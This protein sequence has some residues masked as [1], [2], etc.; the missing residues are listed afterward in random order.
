MEYNGRSRTLFG[1]VYRNFRNVVLN[2]VGIERDLET[3][4]DDYDVGRA[5]RLFTDN[6]EDVLRAMQ[7]YDAEEHEEV[8]MRRDK[9][10]E[11][12]DPYIAEKLPRSLQRYINEVELFFLFDKPVEFRNDTIVPDNEINANTEAYNAFLQVLKDVRFDTTMRKAKRYAGS[13]LESAKKYRAYKDSTTGEAKIGCQV[14]SKQDGH[15]LYVMFNKYGDLVAFANK[16]ELARL[17]I[18]KTIDCI[19]IETKDYIYECIKERGG[20]TVNKFDNLTGKINVI[21]YKQDKAWNGAQRR[22][23]RLELIDS[24]TADIN[25]YFAAPKLVVATKRLKSLPDSPNMAGEVMYVEGDDPDATKS[26]KYLEA[27]TAPEMLQNEISNLEKTINA[28]TFTPPFDFHSLVG[29]GTLSGEAI[30]RAMMLGYVKRN[31][32]REIYDIAISREINLILSIMANV[33]HIKYRDQLNKMVISFDLADPLPEDINQHWKD[34]AELY[35]KGTISL[36]TAVNEIGLYSNMQEEI[37]LINNQNVI[38][39]TT[40]S[41]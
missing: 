5:M 28:D 32:L 24:K 12:K 35:S 17:N 6:S 38:Q 41:I 13:C 22:I 19:D 11:G 2:I 20:W 30:K 4:L 10:R 18:N 33:T 23:T 34:I 7:E 15:D 14:I 27:P 36:K 1:S 21:Y 39:P 9:I 25:N 3:L 8:L 31:M 40:G 29:M 16:Y 37:E 26:I